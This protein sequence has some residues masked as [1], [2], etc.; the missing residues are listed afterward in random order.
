ME[1]REIRFEENCDIKGRSSPS[2][3]SSSSSS[4]SC[5]WPSPAPIVV[6]EGFLCAT[7]EDA[8]SAFGNEMERGAAD[9]R[10]SWHDEQQQQRVGRT[11]AS[12]HMYS[13]LGAEHPYQRP[14]ILAAVGPVSSIHDRA[15]E[16]FYGLVGGTVDYGAKHAAKHGHDRHG[17]TFHRGKLLDGTTSV[18]SF[19]SSLC[20]PQAHFIGHSMGGITIYK[21]QQLLRQGFFDHVLWQRGMLIDGR[22]A[23]NMILS[24]TTISSPFRGTP[25]THVLGSE[26]VPY[27]LVRRFSIGDCLAK[28]VHL[29]AFLNR[30]GHDNSEIE[31]PQSWGGSVK[32]FWSSLMPTLPDVFA[33]AWHFSPSCREQQQQPGIASESRDFPSSQV[34]RHPWT[35]RNGYGLPL[36]WQQLR[37]SDWAEGADCAP[38]DSTMCERHR[39]EECEDEWGIEPSK[40]DG[41]LHN[42]IT[43][44]TERTWY[45]C[46]GAFSTQRNDEDDRPQHTTA[47]IS[48][49]IDWTARW[50]G[51]YDFDGVEPAPAFWSRHKASLTAASSKS[52]SP[53]DDTE[54]VSLHDSGY[55]SP[56]SDDCDAAQNGA[57]AD[58]A[59]NGAS[60]ATKAMANVAP[61][62]APPS[63]LESRLP[64]LGPM[65][66][67]EAWYANDGV[68]P[69]ASQLHP[70]DCTPG[71]CTH[72]IW[73][74]TAAAN[75]AQ[76][77][78]LV[79]SF[80]GAIV[81]PAVASMLGR[82]GD[83]SAGSDF[84][85]DDDNKCEAAS[86][87]SKDATASTARSLPGKTAASLPKA[88]HYH[89]YTLP[90][91]THASLCPIWTGSRRQVDFWRFVGAWLQSVEMAAEAD[92]GV[93]V[94]AGA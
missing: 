4:T 44:G 62:D 40:G 54:S 47:Q 48:S 57:S 11:S 74:S 88:D 41:A 75:E 13:G 85:V 35:W 52:V 7:S 6:V 73:P 63:L 10:R 39:L 58:F 42:S 17:R 69:L 65:T 20:P 19:S 90:D 49:P 32:S 79:E 43:R 55:C 60:T 83:C 67:V 84:E 68:V 51:R 72:T 31:T 86:P 87:H 70:R 92:G 28:A 78:T 71:Q 12:Q 2:S 21:M 33:D 76:R 5:L 26:P 94:T 30:S 25:L 27:P 37:R 23:R 61:T 38:W 36:L 24:I 1:H 8:W 66:E 64:L 45:C 16:L 50:L 34:A 22:P 77:S 15:C 46:V 29:A 82:R 80:F 91:T 93:R 89:S 53:L 18:P 14:I 56:R 3:P 81:S 59:L 9:W